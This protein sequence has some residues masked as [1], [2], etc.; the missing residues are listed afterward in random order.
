MIF[1]DGSGQYVFD[2]A[3]YVP[4]GQDLLNLIPSNLE[5]PFFGKVWGAIGI[6]LFGDNFFGY[7]IFYIIIGVGTVWALYELA[8]L[9]FSKEKAL[10]AASLL[11]FETLLFIHTS[12]DLLE[13][14]PIFFALLGFYAY[15]KKHYYWCAVAMGLSILSKEW[16]T[17][18]VI[19]LFLYH[20]WAT[21]HLRLRELVSPQRVKKLVVFAVILALVVSLPLWAYDAAYH[22]YTQTTTVVTTVKYVNATS[23][24][25]STTTT[26]S[27][28]HSGYITNPLQ[29]FEYY[30]S[31][32][33][34][35]KI[36]K[37]DLQDPWD[38]L[39]WYWVLPL[40]INPS[41]YYVT[42]VTVTTRSS[43]GAVI[44][45]VELHP[46][47]WLGIGNLVV[48]YSIWII[49]PVL[50]FKALKRS[51][52]QLDALI[53][54]LI[55]GTYGPNLLLS[56]VFQ[57]VAYSFYFVNTDPALAL[58]IPMV[59]TFISPDS[60]T[61]QRILMIVWLAAAVAFFVLFFPVHPLDFK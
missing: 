36:T 31:Y 49:V 35:L 34:S 47:D 32:H 61:L 2:E 46:I 55:I 16:G 43:S 58:G 3:Y 52:T 54:S 7:R 48:W 18:F 1:P 20:I 40:D 14:P 17:Y 53:A 38:H 30:Y 11:G 19:A 57:R 9:F 60:Q 39:A 51:A 44:S 10:L 50:I 24:Q 29:N 42:T 23:G 33:T 45:Q 26:T 5:H 8:T 37:Q 6:F 56:A 13:G 59:I 22:P 28:E 21:W 41:P 27:E 25:N 15:F 12:L 4:A